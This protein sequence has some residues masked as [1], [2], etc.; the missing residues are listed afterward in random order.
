MNV[1]DSVQP[2]CVEYLTKRFRQGQHWVEAL[3]D[4]SL[5]IERGT[6]TAIMGASGSGKST[7]MHLMAGLTSPDAGQ[8]IVD[9]QNISKLSDGDLTRFRRQKIGLVFQAFNLIPTLT[10]EDNITLPLFASGYSGEIREKLD[11]LLDRLGIAERRK[12]R[13]DALSGGEQ[14]RVAIARALITDPSIVLADEPTGSLDSATGEETCRIL[15]ELCTE[16][17]RTIVVVTHEPSVAVW[18]ERIIV[19]KDGRLLDEFETAN[20]CDPHSLAAHYQDVLRGA[21]PAGTEV[22]Q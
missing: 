16:Q 11:D 14:Q 10:A 17:N 20:F 19:L 22:A 8:V 2:L 12:H 13:P 18:A 7:L 3:R 9:G 15:K 6:F 1:S 5:T 4:V 21:A